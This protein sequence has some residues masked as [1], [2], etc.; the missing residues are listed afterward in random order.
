MRKATTTRTSSLGGGALVLLTCAA[1]AGALSVASA[2][3]GSSSG[4]PDGGPMMDSGK[5]DSNMKMDSGKPGDSG[6]QNDTG[7]MDSGPSCL[8]FPE[9]VL[10][11]IKNTKPTDPPV[12]V[13]PKTCDTKNEPLIPSSMF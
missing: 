10:G 6:M 1:L 4:N 9:Y 12:K 3:C 11:Q 2:G 5:P 8:T 13:P 7:M